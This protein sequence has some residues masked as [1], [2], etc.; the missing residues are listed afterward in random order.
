MTDEVL[1]A[2]YYNGDDRAFETLFESYFHR[3]RGFFFRFGCRYDAEDLALETLFRVA[4]TRESG[5]RFDQRGTRAKSWIFHIATNLAINHLEKWSHAPPMTSLGLDDD[6]PHQVSPRR[7]ISRSQ[8]SSP[9]EDLIE[10]CISQLPERQR[11]ALVLWMTEGLGIRE[12]AEILGRKY[13]TV[14]RQ[15]KE[16]RD[17]LRQR[18]GRGGLKQVPRGGPL[19]PN[20]VVI[21]SGPDFSL[22]HIQRSEP[23]RPRE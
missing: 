13:G 8:L 18:L 14:G 23:Q 19:P 21:H 9:V 11:S 22:V 12:I 6:C 1:L 16:A 2:S 17:A 5:S 15:L 10:D 7:Y 3:L 4:R 20:A